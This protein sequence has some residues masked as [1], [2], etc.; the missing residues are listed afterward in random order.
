MIN[1]RTLT[2]A[3]LCRLAYLDA[4]ASPMLRELVNRFDD[5]TSAVACMHHDAEE[6]INSD[7]PADALRLADTALDQA[8]GAVNYALDVIG[9]SADLRTEYNRL[10]RMS[11]AFDKA[12]SEFQ[13][14]L[15][16]ARKEGTLETLRD[17][18]TSLYEDLTA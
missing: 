1:L 10:A 17:D 12:Q 6:A 13:E 16:A 3:E 4:K 15:D 14:A 5:I 8:L 9:E 2:D 7:K 18:L 11:D